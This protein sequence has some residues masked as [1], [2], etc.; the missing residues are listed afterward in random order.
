M[1]WL[2]TA[3]TSSDIRQIKECL[4]KVGLQSETELE[5]LPL[6]DCE[7]VFSLTGPSDVDE[8]LKSVPGIIEV[9][10]DSE[11]FPYE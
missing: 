8:K 7:V 1:K 6:G 9:F 10:P 11:P 3:D 5:E 2:V 4:A